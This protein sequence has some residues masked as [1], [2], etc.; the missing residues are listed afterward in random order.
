MAHPRKRR[1]DLP[2]TRRGYEPYEC[3]SAVQKAIRRSQPREAV[4]WGFELWASG[5]DNWAWARLNEILSEDIGIHGGLQFVH[6]VLLMATANKSRLVD[7]L[8]MEVAS[9]QC[10]RIEIA[11]EAFDR[12][13]RRGLRMGR[14]WPHFM[15]HGA[16][17]ID[18]DY[19]A[20]KAGFTDM[21]SWLDKID[22]D[23]EDHF[24][25]RVIEKDD[26]PHNPWASRKKFDSESWLPEPPAED[27]EQQQLPEPT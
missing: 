10:E 20:V 21:E 22:A 8:V 1:P 3:I 11:D 4:Y 6:A 24:V 18:P 14:G 13:T 19:A 27:E 23:S 5:Y 2:K 15:E 25:R 12:H 17:L 26:M 7:W 9:D 16:Q